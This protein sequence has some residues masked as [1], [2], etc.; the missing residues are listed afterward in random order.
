MLV[1]VM[2]ESQ[3]P[4]CAPNVRH[5]CVIALL[6]DCGLLGS[7]LSSSARNLPFGVLIVSGAKHIPS[8]A[9]QNVHHRLIL[10]LRLYRPNISPFLLGVSPIASSLRTCLRHPSTHHR[11]GYT[12]VPLKLEACRSHQYLALLRQLPRRLRR[13][14]SL[15]ITA[16][17][18]EATAAV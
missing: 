18:A 14:P 8:L 4:V 3:T 11:N 2:V 5:I 9:D 10:I 16:A 6:G 1:S 7:W 15:R 12:S 13:A 17:E